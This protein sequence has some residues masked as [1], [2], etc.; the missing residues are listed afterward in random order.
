MTHYNR[1]VDL[2]VVLFNIMS[3]SDDHNLFLA[4]DISNIRLER[5]TSHWKKL[6]VRKFQAVKAEL[7]LHSIYKGDR[8]LDDLL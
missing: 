4:T 7:H 3:I 5:S 1:F 6:E 2:S 8:R